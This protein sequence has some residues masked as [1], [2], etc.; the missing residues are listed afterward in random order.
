MKWPQ[1]V[2]EIIDE[3]NEIDD[4]FEKLEILMDFSA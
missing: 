3:F 4:Q 2:Q 1:P